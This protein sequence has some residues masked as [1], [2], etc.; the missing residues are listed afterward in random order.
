MLPTGEDAENMEQSTMTYVF[1]L[2]GKGVTQMLQTS[3][4][5]QTYIDELRS[6]VRSLQTQVSN[7]TAS[8][9][10]IENRIFVRLQSMQPTIYTREGIPFDDALDAINAKL[11]SQ[12]EKLITSAETLSKFDSEIQNK[13][14][15]EDFAASTQENARLTEA[16][17]ELSNGM[18][19]LQK[20]LQRQRQENQD[21][22]E[23]NI[24]SIKL[25]I[26]Q[27]ALHKTLNDGPDDSEDKYVTRDELKDILAKIKV[28]GPS[29]GSGEDD[30][31]A[32]VEYAL[33]GEGATEEKVKNAFEMLQK[34]QQ[35][36]DSN[37]KAQKGR[38]AEEYN[39]LMK[40]AEVNQ[41]EEEDGDY[42]YDWEDDEGWAS[43]G[44]EYS[45]DAEQFELRSV[46]V[47]F[48]EGITFEETETR[49]YES[50]EGLRSVGLQ[51][52]VDKFL[53]QQSRK[54]ADESAEGEAEDEFEDIVT[55]VEK[56]VLSNRMA[57]S[58]RSKEQKSTHSSS[59]RDKSQENLQE[60]GEESSK[61]K[62]QRKKVKKPK[63]GNGM[64][65]LIDQMKDKQQAVAVTKGPAARVDE[66]KITQKILDTVMPRVENLLIDAFSG[67][68]GGGIKLER[69]E[70]KQLIQQ[71]TALENI[72]TELKQQRVK[73]TMK[74]DKGKVEED[75]RIRVTRD[76]FFG[77]LNQIFPENARVQELCHTKPSATG[78]LP[79]LKKQRDAVDAVPQ[80]PPDAKPKPKQAKGPLT[81]VMN[82]NSKML[83]AN[84]GLL[85]GVD[86]HYYMRDTS[87]DGSQPPEKSKSAMS[88]QENSLA[89]SYDFQRY[90][91]VGGSKPNEQPPQALNMIREKTPVDQSN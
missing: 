40:I 88:S 58:A 89:Q 5:Q 9:D 69:N 34:K 47:D 36:L 59:R 35:D 71:L 70:A 45:D 33:S 14:D 53:E 37:Y 87:Q 49:S 28:M 72:K 39:R 27:N 20:E 91:P 84:Q 12:S 55:E 74:A 64:K 4:Q 60:E 16:F 85:K 73:L 42:D 1:N 44:G 77:F 68:K 54:T 82:R 15:R 52:D 24:Q 62:S 80:V 22:N 79:P 76:E 48:N 61:K 67:G 38:I 86:G 31:S 43:D 83:K 17:Q 10:E 19:S 26:Q 66:G 78:V 3:V 57:K 29:G 18:E 51:A 2:F 6:Q 30:T 23:R 75:M 41:G 8:I 56:E 90:M 13:V 63:N 65:Q 25:Q 81:L 11:Q 50:C 32:I 21:N 46:A 7:L